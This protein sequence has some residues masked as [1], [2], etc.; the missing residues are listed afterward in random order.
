MSDDP[1]PHE[2]PT[3]KPMSRA[4]A[5]TLAILP[6]ISA[7]ISIFISP[8][9]LVSILIATP[10]YLYI[11]AKRWIESNSAHPDSVGT[12]IKSP[13][14]LAFLLFVV[15]VFLVVGGCTAFFVMALSV[16]NFQ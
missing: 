6:S 13:G 10:F 4:T 1:T 5:M 16:T 14:L 9:L 2:F 3:P 8:V 11:G 7:V 12:R 15:N